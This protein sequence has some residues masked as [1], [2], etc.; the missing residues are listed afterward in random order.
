MACLGSLHCSIQFALWSVFIWGS[1]VALPMSQGLY[2]FLC[3]CVYLFILV[4]HCLMMLLCLGSIN[5]FWE[6]ALAWCLAVA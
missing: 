4:V 5:C 6:V 3:V 2:G 1:H